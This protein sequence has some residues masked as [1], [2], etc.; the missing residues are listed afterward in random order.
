MSAEEARPVVDLARELLADELRHDWHE[1]WTGVLKLE[2]GQV[3]KRLYLLHG[4]I[5]FAGSTVEEDMLGANLFRAGKITEAQ[6]RTAMRASSR[7]LG[8]ALTSAGILTTPELAAAVRGQFERIVT[9]VLRWTSGTLRREALAEPPPSD[10]V[11]SLDTPRLLLVGMRQFPDAARLES[12]LGALGRCLRRVTPRPF[13]FDALPPLP[14]E[15]AVLASCTRPAP[16]ARLLA[17]PFER[18]DVVRAIH[19]LLAGSLLEDHVEGD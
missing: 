7:H 18:I 5:V 11:V 6:F 16:V 4:D 14:V 8:D 2:Q 12:Q 13:D 1:R 10:V 9:S 19:A 3:T 15:R 17:L